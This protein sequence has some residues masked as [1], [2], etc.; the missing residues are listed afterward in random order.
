MINTD[1]IY[2]CLTHIGYTYIPICLSRETTSQI[3]YIGICEN[4]DVAPKT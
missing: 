1:R 4:D 2:V 3:T